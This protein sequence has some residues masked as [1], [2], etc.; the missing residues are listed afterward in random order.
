MTLAALE[1]I[2]DRI[3]HLADRWNEV[4]ADVYLGKLKSGRQDICKSFV[5]LSSDMAVKSPSAKLSVFFKAS[6]WCD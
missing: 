6:T 4:P 1:E 3:A 5:T 2:D